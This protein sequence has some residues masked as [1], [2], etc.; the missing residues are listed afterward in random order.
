MT[1]QDF[2]SYFNQKLEKFENYLETSFPALPEPVKSLEESMRYSLFAGG[3]RIRPV[4]T[5]M[6]TECCGKD[7]TIAL[8]FASALEYIH[9]Y[10]LIHD[11][12]PCMDDDDLRR[13]RPTNHIKYGEAMAL[14][15]GDALLTHAFAL[16]SDLKL[17]SELASDILLKIINLIA[18]KAGIFGMVTGQVADI[19]DPFFE[20]SAESLDFTHRHK[21]GALI[22][23]A[24]QIGALIGEASAEDYQ[25][26][27]GFGAELGKCFQIQD[28][29]LDEIGDQK[30]MGK[31]PGSDD[32]NETLTYPKAFGLEKSIELARQS[33]DTAVQYLDKTP[34][35]TDRLRQLAEYILNRDR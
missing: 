35:A 11:D 31:T 14:L 22:S 18:E 8:P 16:I 33:F 3:K 15:A 30:A 4:L 5:M 34:F 13:G 7:E 20:E 23:S 1:N 9:T 17:T 32:K 24:V 27:T 28:D 25:R 29:I 12:L 19:S 10:S 21:T 6:T 26:L 2:K